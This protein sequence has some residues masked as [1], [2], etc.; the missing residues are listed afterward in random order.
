MAAVGQWRATYVPG[1]WLVLCGPSSLVVIEPPG[2]GWSALAAE[3]WQ[4]VLSSSSLVDLA[5]RLAAYGLDSMPSFAAL[6][7]SPD[8]MRSLVR[9]SVRL[10]DPDTDRLVASGEGVQ[11]W[12][13]VGLAELTRVRIDIGSE[14]RGGP[15]RTGEEGDV[16]WL[17]LV[18][19]AVRA[20]SVVLDAS[21]GAGP[22]SPQPDELLA[23]AEPDLADAEPDL[24]FAEPETTEAMTEE[25]LDLGA[26]RTEP[27]PTV[28]LSDLETA[29]TRLV[30]LPPSLPPAPAPPASASPAAPPSTADDSGP[31]VLAVRCPY[32]H[33][34]PP[35]SGRCIDCGVRVTDTEPRPVAQPALATLRV[36]DGN[37]AVLDRVV[38]VGRAPTE[39]GEVPARLLMVPSPAHDISRTHLEIRPDGWRVLVKDLNSTNGTVLIGPDGA[40]RG[41]LPPGEAVPVP[42]GS[43]LELA[44]GIWVALDRPQ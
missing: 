20:S 38:L 12:S 26:T 14:A 1:D 29:D 5:A 4:E 24:P 19:G 41:P 31:T 23:V 9:G 2:A 34:N 28:S 30:A 3:L 27:E 35:G 39:R 10:V 36:T 11:T 6:F 22:D 7:W 33:A 16:L 42:L 15:E 43:V 17:P 18:V 32:G 44:E 40:S 25:E 37:Q 13:E 8:G 21:A